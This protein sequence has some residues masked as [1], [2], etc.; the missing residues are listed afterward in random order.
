M[1]WILEGWIFTLT[2]CLS[3]STISNR[4]RISPSL[5]LRKFGSSWRD[6]SRRAKRWSIEAASCWKIL[7]F[8]MLH[9]RIKQLTLSESWRSLTLFNDKF[10]SKGWVK[11]WISLL[12][13]SIIDIKSSFN[14]CW[15]LIICSCSP[16]AC[17]QVL[18]NAWRR[19]CRRWIVCFNC[20]YCERGI[21]LIRRSPRWINLFNSCSANCKRSE[22][23]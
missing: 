12:N 9:I 2:W 3:P 20:S 22:T 18:F 5:E 15:V 1:I 16:R 11:S 17:W 14:L 10:S 23:V 13:Q 6:C 4:S 8:I 7:H 19:S 21:S